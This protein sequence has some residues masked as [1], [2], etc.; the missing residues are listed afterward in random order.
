MECGPAGGQPPDTAAL[1]ITTST[2][3][4]HHCKLAKNVGDGELW[5]P[6]SWGRVAGR[7]GVLDD[8]RGISVPPPDGICIKRDRETPDWSFLRR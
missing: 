3:I 5:Y 6:R 7:D 4:S 8:V 2:R 1:N